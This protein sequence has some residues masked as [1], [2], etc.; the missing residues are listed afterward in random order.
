LGVVG[1]GARCAA[2]VFGSKKEAT[3]TIAEEHVSVREPKKIGQLASDFR[4]P[5]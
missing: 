1:A 4:F 5:Q 2:K 3:Q